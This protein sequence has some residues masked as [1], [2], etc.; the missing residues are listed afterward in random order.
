MELA[1]K[2]A[3]VTGGASGIGQAMCRRFAAE[4]ASVV[5]ADIDPPG[6]AA[7][8]HDIG[9][10]A[11]PGDMSVEADLRALVDTALL[12]YDRIDLFCANAGILWGTRPDDAAAIIGAD[13]PDEAWERIWR[14]NVMAHVYAARAVVPAMLDQGGG[15]ILVTASAAGLLTLVGNAPYSVTKHAAV[16]LA[17]WLAIT[18][19]DQGLSVSCLC[20][21]LVRTDMLAGATP[22]AKEQGLG[23]FDVLEPHE[24]ADAVVEGLRDERF[25]ILP[26]PEVLTYL[27]RKTADYDRWL[28]GMRRLQARFLSLG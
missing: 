22:A 7:V 2:V 4:G 8:A 11:V 18:Y 1:G 10:L 26:H 21:Q 19:G 5:V 6:A 23:D 14:V 13:A 28:A 15:H 25:L 12:S 20:P 9:G 3:V 16:A 24:V 17:E 27:Q